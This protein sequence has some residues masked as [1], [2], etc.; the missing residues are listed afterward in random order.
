MTTLRRVLA[1]ILPTLI[2]PTCREA[3]QDSPKLGTSATAD[4]LSS[5]RS[6]E[7]VHWLV[8]NQFGIGIVSSKTAHVVRLW[9]IQPMVRLLDTLV[10]PVLDSSEVLVGFY[11]RRHRSRDATIVAVAVHVDGPVYN[12]IHKAWQADTV[13][14]RLVPTSVAGIDCQ[15]EGAGA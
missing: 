4:T 6:D 2:L 11:C 10:V 13:V 1:L 3:R 9:R 5:A 12:T 8:G 15:N 7:G 14:G